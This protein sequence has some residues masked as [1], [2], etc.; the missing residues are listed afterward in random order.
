MQIPKCKL[1]V[2]VNIVAQLLWQS[3]MHIEGYSVI[4][5]KM[6]LYCPP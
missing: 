4:V 1:K 3:T 6:M 5:Q 2:F